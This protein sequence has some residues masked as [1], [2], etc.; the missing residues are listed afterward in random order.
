MMAQIF[1][2]QSPKED[3][4]EK[5]C[6]RSIRTPTGTTMYGFGNKAVYKCDF[7]K[8]AVKK[9]CVA[10]NESTNIQWASRLGISY[11][12]SFKKK[13]IEQSQGI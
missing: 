10:T 7:S 11:F 5:A 6:L 9:G 2:G 12:S 4:P 1:T 3:A 13:D 8:K